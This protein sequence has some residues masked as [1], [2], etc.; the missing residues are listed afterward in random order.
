[1]QKLRGIH[2][3]KY[4]FKWVTQGH[5]VYPNYGMGDIMHVC[6]EFMQF[7]NVPFLNIWSQILLAIWT[8]WSFRPLRELRLFCHY[9]Y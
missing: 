1:M 3:A 6:T 8:N 2:K 5:I 7:F 9:F 4:C